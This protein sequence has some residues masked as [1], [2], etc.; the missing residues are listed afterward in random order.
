MFCRVEKSSTLK[1]E[2]AGPYKNIFEY[3]TTRRRVLEVCGPNTFF[4]VGCLIHTALP[5]FTVFSVLVSKSVTTFRLSVG[6]IL[7]CFLFQ[8]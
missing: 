7:I 3:E 6:Y 5:I 2:A 4:F 8:S 1:M